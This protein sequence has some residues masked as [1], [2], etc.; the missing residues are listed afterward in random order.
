MS[1]SIKDGLMIEM[2]NQLIADATGIVIV[3]PELHA[4]VASN[5]YIKSLSAFKDAARRVFK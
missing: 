2:L 4:V 5:L 1:T 3:P